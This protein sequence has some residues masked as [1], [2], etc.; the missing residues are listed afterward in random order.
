FFRNVAIYLG[1]DA[2]RSVFARVRELLVPD[3]LLFVGHAEIG[4]AAAEAGFVVEPRGGGFA[5][6]RLEGDAGS[7]AGSAAASAAGLAAGSSHETVRAREK[8][9]TVSRRGRVAPSVHEPERIAPPSV[10]AAEPS[11]YIGRA[12]TALAAGDLG[13]AEAEIGRAL[14]LAPRDEEAL[15]VAA[16]VADRRGARAEG[17]RYRSRAM[18]EHLSR[19]EPPEAGHA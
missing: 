3:G 19:S 1:E 6:R 12:R 10:V 18:R 7:A 8:D 5:L 9:A 17:D 15:L 4:A 16:E 14:Y 13:A 2:R 11:E